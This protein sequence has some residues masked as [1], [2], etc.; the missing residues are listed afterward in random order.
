MRLEMKHL[1]VGIAAAMILAV[2]D[3][4]RAQARW[5]IHNGRQQPIL[6]PISI[7]SLLQ[8]ITVIV[9]P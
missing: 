3:P 7:V 4:V 8:S 6:P 2:I 5:V 1:L 9:V